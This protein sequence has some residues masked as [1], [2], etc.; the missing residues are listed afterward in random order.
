MKKLYTSISVLF[1]LL[2]S[3]QLHAQLDT[4][5]GRY[6]NPIFSNVTAANN[7]V[8]GTPAGTLI[9]NIFQPAGDTASMRGL[10][11]FAHGGSFIGGSRTDQDVSTL[12]TRF[13]KMG[14]VTCSIDYR[15]GFFPIDSVNAT[16]AVIK[17]S[18]DMKAAVRFFRQDAATT[19]T[20]KIH[21]DYIFAGG[22]S[23]GAFMSLHLAYL[24]KLSEVP[25]WIDIN[26]LGGL[27]G[28]SGNPGYSS[29]VNAVINLCGALGDSTWLE[30]G[31]I[32]VVSMHGTND[33]TVPYATAIIYVA[34]FPIMEVDGSASI[35]VRA[36]HVGVNN[37]FYTWPGAGHVPYAGTS[38]TAMAY[39]DTTVNYVRD[40]LCP[41]V[42]APSVLTSVASLANKNSFRIFPNPT[43]SN[44]TIDLSG[45]S[46]DAKGLEIFVYD[47]VGRKIKSITGISSEKISFPCTDLSSGIYIVKVFSSS[48]VWFSKLVVE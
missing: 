13:A 26:S 25:T 4:S 7:V 45:L 5:F 48:G 6:C 32:P 43:T 8:Y 37:P 34:G 22:S 21:P 29:K 42:A 24:D 11:V 46:T 35:K 39:M 14:Y 1:F 44:V 30:P 40:F 28:N 12:C 2:A 16:K 18:Q 3:F 20:Y 31:D 38:T 19:N 33:G 23:A 36:D 15:L 9:M 10:I 47:N 41:I 17:A 27:E